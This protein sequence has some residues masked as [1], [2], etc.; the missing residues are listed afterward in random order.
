[1]MQNFIT[2][3]ARAFALRL[4]VFLLACLLA[5]CSAVRLG[6]AS[7]D[8]VTYWWLNGYVDFTDAQ[9]P[10]VRE[11]IDT[12]FAWHRQTQLRDYARLLAHFQQRMQGSGKVMPADMHA[13][14]AE[15]RKR[16]MQVVDKALPALTELALS[17]EPR[18]IEHLEKKFASNNESFRKDYLR[19]SAEDRQAFRFKKVMQHA[20]YW[21]GNFSEQQE[22]QIR[23][24]SDARPLNNELWMAERVR[25]QQELLRLLKKIH[26]E[27]PSRETV[28]AMLRNYAVA[29]FDYFT[30]EENKAFFDGTRDGMA[31]MVAT[32]VNIA[33][34]E[35]RAHAVKRLQ[36]WIEDFQ[37]MAAKA[38]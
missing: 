37:L 16:T 23:A 26:A 3:P 15:I 28:S 11:R 27:H 36:K 6:Y 21:F 2:Q 20:E 32:V 22:A 19:G 12:L 24:A 14:Y 10:W 7:G 38:S 30:Y 4:S 5:A 25:R 9:K 17:L 31:Q 18:Q 13:D 29:S 35:Q 8:T 33:T 1:M 34:P